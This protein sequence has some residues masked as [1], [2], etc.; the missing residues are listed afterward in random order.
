M[1]SQLLAARAAALF[2]SDL[3]AESRPSTDTVHATI[4]ATVRARG[5]TRGCAA[6]MAAAYGDCPQTAMARIR[7]A[8]D[9]VLTAYGARRPEPGTTLALAA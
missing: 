6:E 8:R 2:A 1:R 3:S 7:W 4:A 9:T 5:G